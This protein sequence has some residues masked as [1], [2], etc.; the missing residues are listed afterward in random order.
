MKN[1]LTTITPDTLFLGHRVTLMVLDK[2]ISPDAVRFDDICK[3]PHFVTSIHDNATG[4]A[5]AVLVHLTRTEGAAVLRSMYQR[6]AN[7]R[8]PAPYGMQ[9]DLSVP[10][11][12]HE[13]IARELQSFLV[14]LGGLHALSPAVL[15]HSFAGGLNR[16]NWRPIAVSDEL[17]VSVGTRRK[18]QI[19]HYKQ[20]SIER[21][22]QHASNIEDTGRPDFRVEHIEITPVEAEQDDVGFFNSPSRA[23]YRFGGFRNARQLTLVSETGHKYRVANSQ[24]DG[25][26]QF[27]TEEAHTKYIEEL[28]DVLLPE[29]SGYSAVFEE[30]QDSR[31]ASG[32]VRFAAPADGG[33]LY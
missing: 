22:L 29:L 1:V 33:N 17:I 2:N 24:G 12:L 7:A 30:A 23:S 6:G 26:F 18:N 25:L 31:F 10:A 11:G 21:R 9:G 5:Y 4:E 3:L 14:E 15:M 19:V 28:L 20:Y 27:V 8:M 16:M 32:Q 13:F